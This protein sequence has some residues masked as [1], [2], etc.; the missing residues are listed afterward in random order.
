YSALLTVIMMYSCVGQFTLV[1]RWPV[2]IFGLS[3]WT[4]IHRTPK[5][6]NGPSSGRF[7]LCDLSAHLK[8]VLY[9]YRTHTDS[10]LTS[11]PSGAI[12]FCQELC[13]LPVTQ[14]GLLKN[15]YYVLL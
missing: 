15:E 4:A 6:T 1:V 8:V 10:A 3:R 2:L 7:D 5:G 14:S 11:I 13:G 12:L 9:A